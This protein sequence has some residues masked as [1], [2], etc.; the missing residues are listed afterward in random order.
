MKVEKSIHIVVFDKPRSPY[1][2]GQH[3]YKRWQRHYYPNSEYAR[4]YP[5]DENG[6]VFPYKAFEVVANADHYFETIFRGY[7]E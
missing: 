3:E 6:E 5:E 7:N 1:D 4:W 2:S